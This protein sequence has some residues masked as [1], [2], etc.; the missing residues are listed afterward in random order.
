MGASRAEVEISQ[1]T[2]KPKMV[3]TDKGR[4]AAKLEAVM[5]KEEWKEFQ[6]PA[7]AKKWPKPD[8]MNEK[9]AVRHVRDGGEGAYRD[10]TYMIVT[11]WTEKTR[12]QYR[13][14]AKAPGSKSHVR[15]EKYAKAKSIGEALKLG[16]YPLDWCFDYEHGF[17]KVLGGEIRDEPIDPTRV[18]DMNKLTDVDHCLLQWYRRELAKK[19]GLKVQDLDSVDG[20]PMMLRA[21][22]L[23]ANRHAEG[24]LAKAAKENRLISEDEVEAVLSTWGFARNTGRLNVLPG[25]KEWVW[26]D[27]LGLLRDRVGDIHL[28]KPTIRYP[29]V[30][31]LLCQ[32]LQAR[33]PDEV[34]DFKFTSLNLNKNYAARRHRDGN[35]FGPSM[36]KGFGKYQHGELHVFPSDDRAI[37][38]ESKLPE[39]DRVTLDI[40]NN[41]AMFNGNS[42]HE[43]SDYE[44]DRYSVVYFTMGC[45]AKMNDACRRDLAA[46]GMPVPAVDEDPH[47]LLSAP[48]GYGKTP[49]RTRG[50]AL[51]TWAVDDLERHAPSKRK[52]SIDISSFASASKRLDLK[53]SLKKPAGN[54]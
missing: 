51:R 49:G 2:G 39:S 16:S 3:R 11:R 1:I 25:D 42:A 41:L 33:L 4:E 15:Y 32:W 19:Y 52:A 10:Q 50:Q 48:T 7:W 40:R 45:H 21:H 20:E 30:V 27:T 9:V 13:P 38:D 18:E 31:A 28:T 35:N 54:K 26:S 53:R 29:A 43:V 44:G 47:S 24:F 6:T 46:I 34:K 36:I 14:H 5:T 12:V 37:K 23:H 8:Y 22:R 17:I